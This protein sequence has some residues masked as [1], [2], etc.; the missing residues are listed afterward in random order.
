MLWRT[1]TTFGGSSEQ[2]TQSVSRGKSAFVKKLNDS[3]FVLGVVDGI[4][5]GCND[6]RLI[7]ELV[8]PFKKR[9]IFLA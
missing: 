2:H 3:S 4:D 7:P 1:V 8:R 6:C 5:N 9:C